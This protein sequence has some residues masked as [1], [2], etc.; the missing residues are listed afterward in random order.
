M[1]ERSMGGFRDGIGGLDPPPWKITSS[2]SFPLEKF[3]AGP[4]KKQLDSS[5]RIA[6]HWRFVLTSVKYV[7]DIKNVVKIQS[8][9]N[10]ILYP[11]MRSKV[12][13]SCQP[14]VTVM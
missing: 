4:L 3:G 8:P 10:S 11:H 5:G 6:S 7:N 1:S 9:D 12:L 14:R 2:Y 13:L